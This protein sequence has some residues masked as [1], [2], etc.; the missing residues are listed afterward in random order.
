MARGKLRSSSRNSATA[1]G[2]VGWSEYDEGFGA[3]GVTAAI[4]RLAA[5]VVGK[6]A[7]Q[8]ERIYAEAM[9]TI[10]ALASD[11]SSAVERV[12]GRHRAAA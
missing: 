5:R 9:A 6:N 10:A 11:W 12:T 2:V 8:H 1:D 3:P 4:E 7:C